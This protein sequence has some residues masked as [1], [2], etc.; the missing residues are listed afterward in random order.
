MSPTESWV[1][2]VGV[3]ID[4]EIKTTN[5]HKDALTE[6]RR[7]TASCLASERQGIFYRGGVPKRI[8]KLMQ[9]EG[10]S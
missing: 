3:G 2:G 7:T 6:L 1:L 8:R 9:S 4:K 5:P 10:V